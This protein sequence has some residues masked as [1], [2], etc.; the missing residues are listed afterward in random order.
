M[1]AR[2]RPPQAPLSPSRPSRALHLVGFVLATHSGTGGQS[3]PFGPISW[4]HCSRI[5]TSLAG[6]STPTGCPA[7]AN[8]RALVPEQRPGPLARRAA[9]PSWRLLLP[10]A[11]RKPLPYCTCWPPNP[12]GG[13]GAPPLGTHLYPPPPRLPHR[14]SYHLGRPRAPPSWLQQCPFRRR[15]QYGTVICCRTARPERVG[16]S[17]KCRGAIRLDIGCPHLQNPRR[18]WLLRRSGWPP[19]LYRGRTGMAAPPAY[20]PGRGG[21]AE[22]QTTV[23]TA[24][25]F[26]G[27]VVV[28]STLVLL[29]PT[30]PPPPGA[31][32]ISAYA[33][34]SRPNRC[35]PACFSC[36]TTAGRVLYVWEQRQVC[37]PPFYDQWP[38]NVRGTPASQQQCAGP[39]PRARPAAYLKQASRGRRHEAATSRP[40]ADATVVLTRD[41]G[42]VLCYQAQP[43]E[44][45]GAR[46]QCDKCQQRQPRDSTHPPPVR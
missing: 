14:L 29:P 30:D 18:T 37:V 1:A 35:R 33:H 19:L 39:H 2:D 25:R 26:R 31:S 9:R 32:R 3:R 20:T 5:S 23:I 11:P 27:Y 44:W 15:V 7:R 43:D 24:A 21:V 4:R 10:P 45:G 34:Y 40:R 28:M 8:S 12:G 42:L 22:T 41:G 13:V 38:S 36:H 17:G 16:A 6:P 46:R